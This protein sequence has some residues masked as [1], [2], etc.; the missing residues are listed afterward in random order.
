MHLKS[1]CKITLQNTVA[2][3]SCTVCLETDKQCN[4]GH[5]AHSNQLTGQI[6]PKMMSPFQKH[7]L[8]RGPSLFSVSLYCKIITEPRGN[9][10]LPKKIKNH[11]FR[12]MLKK[13]KLSRTEHD[14]NKKMLIISP[15]CSGY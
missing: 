8:K 10:N 6:W 5:L 13:R 1:S 4:H 2:G 11:Y 14:L 9:P 3:G 7:I 15:F 12:V